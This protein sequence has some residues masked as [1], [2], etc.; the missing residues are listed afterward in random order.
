MLRRG[1]CWRGDLGRIWGVSRDSRE[2]GGSRVLLAM[3][4]VR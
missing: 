4:I 3:V 1:G 2:N